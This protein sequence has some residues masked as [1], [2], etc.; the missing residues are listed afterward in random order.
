MEKKDY[1]SIDDLEI[2]KIAMEIGEIIWEKVEN[3]DWFGKQTV[4]TQVVRSADSIAS[5]IAEGYGRFFFK[6]RRQFIFYSRGSLLETKTWA[7]K[8]LR[9]KLITQQEYDFLIE[10]LQTL[11]Y[12][13]NIYLKKLKQTSPPS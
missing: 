1:I 9:R 13:I 3:W 7:T 8:A 11:H 4:G 6:E 2:Y 10:K 5:N 12:K